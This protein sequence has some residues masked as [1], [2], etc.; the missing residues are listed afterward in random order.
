MHDKRRA[1]SWTEHASHNRAGGHQGD[2]QKPAR[3]PI[4]ARPAW[5]CLLR[6]LGPWA[7][8]DGED[9]SAPDQTRCSA[10]VPCPGLYELRPGTPLVGIHPYP[11][12]SGRRGSGRRP[13]GLDYGSDRLG[14]AGQCQCVARGV[15]AS[16]G[17][18]G[19]SGR[20]ARQAVECASRVR[21]GKLMVA[22]WQVQ[23]RTARQCVVCMHSALDDSGLTAARSVQ[24]G[25]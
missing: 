1:T 11:S 10:P 14:R 7:D 24:Q 12:A 25:S 22:A 3:A 21:G 2:L 6:V 4:R 9:G 8:G 5:R 17:G 15:A 20:A 18:L 16:S 23:R 13:A 19:G